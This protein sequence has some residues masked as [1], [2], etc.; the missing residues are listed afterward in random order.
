MES[1]R[2]FIA[3]PPGETIKEQLALRAMSQKEFA[4]RMGLTE[5]HVTNLLKGSVRLTTNTAMRLESVL[6]IP[7][8]FWEN[9]EALYRESLIRVEEEN[10][11]DSDIEAA[12]KFPYSEMVR[13]GWILPAKNAY[14]RVSNLR[15]YFEVSTLRLIDNP[16]INRIACRRRLHD[17]KNDYAL[18]AWAQRAKIEARNRETKAININGLKEIIPEI[19][20]LNTFPPEVFCPKLIELFSDKEVA[21]IFLP[22]IKNSFIHGASFYDGK[23]SSSV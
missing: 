20:A 7:A 17:D 9:L 6:G 15:K 2:T 16:Q 10:L 1:S 12:K 8:I 14:E 21:L 3:V 22:L 13:H 4:F 19:R 23:K 18:L 5:K 11:T